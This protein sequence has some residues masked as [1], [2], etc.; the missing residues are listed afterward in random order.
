MRQE[1]GQRGNKRTHSPVWQVIWS[2]RPRLKSFADNSPPATE[3]GI[4][5][6]WAKRF[7]TEMVLILLKLL[8][9]LIA[10]Y[11]PEN[12]RPVIR[13]TDTSRKK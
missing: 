10:G 8:H 9:L 3:S 5:S 7:G 13:W 2:V 6:F 12:K 11:R 4:L 1:T